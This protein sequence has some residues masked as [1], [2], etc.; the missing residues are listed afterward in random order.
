MFKSDTQ[1]LCR[2]CGNPIPRQTR[3]MSAGVLSPLPLYT[4]EQCQALLV[5]GFAVEARYRAGHRWNRHISYLLVWDGTSYA[6]EYFCSDPC[7]LRLAYAA[8]DE[9]L[10]MPEYQIAK[11]ARQKEDAA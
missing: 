3:I 4:I 9:G 10:A 6:D 11:E 2:S 1:P 5:S 7:R 8:A